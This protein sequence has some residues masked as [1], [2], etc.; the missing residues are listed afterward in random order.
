MNQPPLLLI[1]GYAATR[2]D[3]DPGFLAAL[4]P[5]HRVI[6]PDNRGVGSAELGAAEL[7]VDLMA[8]DLERLL[9]R[10]GIERLPIVG[11]S[12]GGFVA[13][14]LALRAPQ[15]V[16][17]LV[18]IASD[19]GGAAAVPA[20]PEV[21]ARLVDRSGTPRE[22]ASRLIALLFP[23]RLAGEIDRQFGELVAAARAKLAPATL[24]AQE[25]AMEAWHRDE[26]A[27]PDRSA[28]PTLVLH[29]T[30]DVVIPTANAEALGARWH[31]ARVELF[32]GC[33]HAAMAQEP[34]AAAAAI[35]AHVASA[36]R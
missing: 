30:E 17:A 1:N 4:E 2:D 24:S 27:A 13:Q 5:S 16:S 11:W 33:A 6:R 10:E 35:R 25:A 29:G 12:M 31:G 3:W 9:D 19:P 8:A 26:R 18:L 34:V 32:V 15:R 28:P 14:S 20:A 21:W 22:Q 36:S 23:P 7:T